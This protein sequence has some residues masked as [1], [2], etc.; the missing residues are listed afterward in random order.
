MDVELEESRERMVSLACPSY[1]PSRPSEHALVKEAAIAGTKGQC[2]SGLYSLIWND[3]STYIP[4]NHKSLDKQAPRK[5]VWDH[6]N[7]TLE[8]IRSQG[9]FEN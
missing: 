5:K 6:A 2:G 1:Y 3:E 8:Y 4:K 9:A 7:Q